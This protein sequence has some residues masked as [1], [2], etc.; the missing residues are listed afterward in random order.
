METCMRNIRK[1]IIP[2]AVAVIAFLVLMPMS[3]AAAE[4][5]DIQMTGSSAVEQDQEFEIKVQFKAKDIKHVKGTLVYDSSAME[6]VTGDGI[7][8]E[9]GVVEFDSETENGSTVTVSFT[10]KALDVSDTTVV[11]EL[12]EGTD[13]SDRSLETVAAT[14]DIEV[15][16]GEGITDG[17]SEDPENPFRDPEKEREEELI[18]SGEAQQMMEEEAAEKRNIIRDS[19]AMIII[20]AILLI[21]AI[22]VVAVRRGRRRRQEEQQEDDYWKELHSKL[23][24]QNKEEDEAP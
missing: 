12:T 20:T 24:D 2:A 10:M 1:F 7:S 14:R 21:A 16:A 22:I 3:A 8:S 6:F 13:A 11:A 17:S 9:A 19:L 23:V 4:K 18:A 5:V 15:I